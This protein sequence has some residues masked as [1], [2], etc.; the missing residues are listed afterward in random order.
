MV[1]IPTSN[2]FQFK[3]V[4]KHPDGSQYIIQILTR[5][6]FYFYFKAKLVEQN[7]SD[8]TTS[9]KKQQIST[10]LKLEEK[11]VYLQQ[12]QNSTSLK[13]QQQTELLQQELNEMSNRGK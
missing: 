8:R 2:K 12:A 13:L 4:L 11:T 7:L 5:L 10:S 9:L 6:F 1:I 3:I